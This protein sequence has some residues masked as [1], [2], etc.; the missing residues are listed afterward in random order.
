MMSG[1]LHWGGAKLKFNEIIKIPFYEN[2]YNHFLDGICYRC[3]SSEFLNY[4]ILEKN[5]IIDVR[6]RRFINN[7]MGKRKYEGMQILLKK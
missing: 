7:K 4:N 3:I 1:L 5:F 2:K 6:Y